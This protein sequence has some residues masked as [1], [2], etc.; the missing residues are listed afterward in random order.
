[1]EWWH[2]KSPN[3]I[4]PHLWLSP[5]ASKF[6]DSIDKPEWNVLEHGAGGSTLWFAKRCNWVLAIESKK[7]WYL[8]LLEMTKEYKKMSVILVDNIISNSGFLPYAIKLGTK[9][10][11]DFLFIDGEPLKDRIAWAFHA[12]NLVRSGGWVCFDNCNREELRDAREYLKSI[13]AEVVT[14]D[15][16][17]SGNGVTTEYLVTEFY[18]LK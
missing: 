10:Q 4:T 6:L 18:R 8:K 14:F 12:K 7:E 16:N 9:W 2:S 11:F 15:G 1:M 5:E 3:A 13:S 17:T